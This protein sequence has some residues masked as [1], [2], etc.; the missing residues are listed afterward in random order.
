TLAEWRTE[1]LLAAFGGGSVADVSGGG[2]FLP[3][4]PG[5]IAEFSFVWDIVDGTRI[6][7][8]KAERCFV[9]GSIEAAIAKNDWM[10][11]PIEVSILAPVNEPRAWSVVGDN[12]VATDDES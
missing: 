12:F 3:P 4:E 7:R 8:I 6:K 2:E 9:V 1:T 11:L 5:T 10:G